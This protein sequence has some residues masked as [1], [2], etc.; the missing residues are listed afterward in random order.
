MDAQE[1]KK[2]LELI[3]SEAK[4]LRAAGVRKLDLGGVIV[5]LSDPPPPESPAE[6][7]PA[8]A[9]G[10]SPMSDP[11]TF[12]YRDGDPVPRLRAYGGEGKA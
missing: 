10:A 12:G 1:M 7:A 11:A 3:K 5:E 9:P 4:D 6:P 2:I 8:P